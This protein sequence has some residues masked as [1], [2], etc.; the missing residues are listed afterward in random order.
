VRYPN[1]RV[2]ASVGNLAYDMFKTNDVTTLSQVMCPECDYAE[3]EQDDKLGY[4]LVADNSTTPKST[5][6]W[7]SELDIEIHEECP[8]CS[9]AL[10]QPI[11]Y[12]DPAQI[13]VLEYP[14]NNIK[15]SHKISFET[16]GKVTVLYLRGIVYFGDFHFTSRIISSTGDIWFNDGISTGRSCEEDGHLSHISDTRLKTC[17]GKDLVLAVYAQK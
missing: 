1:G 10:I 6:K 4:T 16:D 17:R 11:F 8:N 12:D 14:N 13:L 3:P 15:T 9:S 2:G 7:I 5:S